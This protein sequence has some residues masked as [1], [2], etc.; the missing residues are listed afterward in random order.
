MTAEFIEDNDYQEIQISNSADW[1][2]FHSPTIQT[3]NDPF[4]AEGEDLI[5]IS[6][7]GPAFRRKMNRDL[8]KKFTGIDGTGTQQ[9]LLQ[10]AITGCA[11]FDLVEPRYNLEYL[12]QIFATLA[13]IAEQLYADISQI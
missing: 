4:K 12:S 11:M 6:G 10:Q 1:I 2:K 3:T 8:Q 5:K 13:L 7:L 9:I